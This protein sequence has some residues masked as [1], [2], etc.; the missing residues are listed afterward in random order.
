MERIG[1]VGL[2]TMGAAMAGHLL[3]AGHPLTVWNRTLARAAD[4]ASAGASVAPTP[5]ALAAA[6][7]TSW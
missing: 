5:A 6:R 1:F 4:L 3:R 2:G 7:A